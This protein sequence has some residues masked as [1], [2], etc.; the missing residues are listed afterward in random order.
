[1]R[2][3]SSQIELEVKMA[4]M[5]GEF[6]LGRGDVFRNRLG[7]TVKLPPDGY[8]QQT[9]NINVALWT[10]DDDAVT[11]LQRN[12]IDGDGGSGK[13]RTEGPPDDYF[14]FAIGYKSRIP[15]PG[16]AEGITMRETTTVVP[17]PASVVLGGVRGQPLHREEGQDCLYAEPAQ[18]KVRGAQSMRAAM[19][20]G[21]I[22]FSIGGRTV[23]QKSLKGLELLKSGEPFLGS[24][25]FFTNGE[26]LKYDSISIDGEL[27]PAW[28]EEQLL[29]LAELELRKLDPSR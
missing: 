19:A 28:V 7:V 16:A 3:G 21:S 26:I 14:V 13:P 1:V 8:S 24:V 29:S 10:R 4:R 22:A 18:G 23:P 17:M 9:P 15:L 2:S 6:R 12:L 27:N 11:A 20:P 25:T 5:R